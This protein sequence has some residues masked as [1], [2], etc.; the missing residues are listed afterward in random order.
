[1]EHRIEVRPTDDHVEIF[2]RGRKIID[3][4]HALELKEAS[5]PPVLYVPRED[6]QMRVFQ[7]STRETT[8]PYKGVAHYFSLADGGD[9]DADAVWTYETPKPGVA[10]I[11]ERLAFYPDKVE[12]RRTPG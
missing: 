1:M 8:C 12:I 2:W 4:T 7:R 6:A 11:A 3:T 10:A 5:Y 9:S